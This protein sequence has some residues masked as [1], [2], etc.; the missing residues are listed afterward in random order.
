MDQ[1]SDKKSPEYLLDESCL[2]RIIGEALIIKVFFSFEF[3]TFSGIK[4]SEVGLDGDGCSFFPKKLLAFDVHFKLRLYF[5]GGCIVPSPVLF[6][7]VR[8]EVVDFLDCFEES[9]FLTRQFH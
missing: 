9:G 4:R 2:L 7:F 8:S 1:F 5:E 3:K 6:A